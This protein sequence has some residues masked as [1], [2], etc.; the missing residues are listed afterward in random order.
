VKAALRAP[1]AR[2]LRAATRPPFTD[3]VGRK[4]LFEGFSRAQ[5]HVVR[6]LRLAVAGWP[7]WPR[8]LRVVFLSDLHTGSHAGDVQRLEAIVAEATQ[9]APD[10][11]LFGGDYVNMQPLGGG[12]VPPR[13]T[14]AVLSR[15]A[16]G[17]GR[18]AVLG[19]H[20]IIYG[21]D[22]VAEALRAHEI[23]VLDDQAAS[24]R[25]EG[26]SVTI[27]GLPDGGIERPEP[28]ALLATLSP[29]EPAIILSHDPV[30]FAD[31]R[32]ST[33]LMLAG[34]THGG[35][36]TLPWIGP[37]VN[38]SKAPLRWT[39]GLIEDGGRQLYVTSGLGTSGIPLRVGSPPEIVLLSINGP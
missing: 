2:L 28:P 17:H 30:W 31:V 27:L 13:V 18:F 1:F 38:A 25:L 22:E 37:M 4:G 15:L 12:R 23:T 3:V 11:V 20:D 26:T 9:L 29:Q 10:L 34:H 14:A 36:I 16:G 7:R 33:H 8:P 21:A 32:A 39:Y 35:Q 5:P 6:K 24:I 19:N